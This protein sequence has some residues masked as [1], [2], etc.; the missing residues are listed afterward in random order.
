MA[1]PITITG[2]PWVAGHLPPYKSSGGSFYAAIHNASTN[3]IFIFKADSDDPESG[4]TL[5]DFANSASSDFDLIV[6]S[7]VQDDDVI[8]FAYQASLSS[9][10]DAYYYATFNMATDLWVVVDELIEDPDNAPLEFWISIA[11]RSDG[12]VVVVYNGDTDQV[13]GGSKERVDANVRTSGPDTWGGPIAIWGSGNLDEHFGNPNCVLGTSDGT[14]I[15]WQRTTATIDPPTAWTTTV[16]ATLDSTDTLSTKDNVNQDSG[17]AL[18]GQQNGVSYDDGGTQRMVWN[19]TNGAS[20][21]FYWIAT[22]VSGDLSFG[23]IVGNPGSDNIFENGEV[24]IC[25]LAELN[26]DLHQVYSGGGVFGGD[27]D[28]WYS[29]SID[30]GVTWDENEE[31]DAIT[32][33]FISA[34]IYTRGPNTVLAY[35]YEDGGDTKYNEKILIEGIPPTE[36]LPILKRRINTLLRM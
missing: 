29:T 32:C 30:D 5:Q 8:H 2:Q 13:M 33:N 6:V 25:S 36:I 35:V 27:Q 1:L 15:I 21:P 23:S 4:W 11:V 34:N 7:S 31:I 16:G 24:S 26:G 17:G 9:V 22:E 3:E 14:H 19:G 12:D 28:I 18:L 20:D 10:V